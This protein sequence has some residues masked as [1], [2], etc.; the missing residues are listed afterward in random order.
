MTNR[1]SLGQVSAILLG[2]MLV[3]VA[4][5]HQSYMELCVCVVNSLGRASIAMALCAVLT[6][7][8]DLFDYSAAPR[9]GRLLAWLQV[10]AFLAG[11][12][13]LVQHILFALEIV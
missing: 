3:T 9:L 12:F 2:G 4:I 13:F 5:A 1:T 7:L 6:P 10:L 11:V 8:M